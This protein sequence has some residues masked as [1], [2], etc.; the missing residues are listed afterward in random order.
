M[1]SGRVGSGLMLLDPNFGGI[2]L[3]HK[4]HNQLLNGYKP[5]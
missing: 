4:V 2:R 1:V 5:N 3:V